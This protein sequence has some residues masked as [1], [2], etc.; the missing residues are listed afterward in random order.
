VTSD[1][2]VSGETVT[3]RGLARRVDDGSIPNLDFHGPHVHAGATLW[4]G[5]R[6]IAR[7]CGLGG[8][9]FNRIGAAAQSLAP[10]APLHATGAVSGATL[11]ACSWVHNSIA[12]DLGYGRSGEKLT[13][14]PDFCNA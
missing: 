1:G 9:K 13:L 14:A 5:L 6:K 2:E 7:N 8:R 4:C 10:L 12:S 3:A 11:G